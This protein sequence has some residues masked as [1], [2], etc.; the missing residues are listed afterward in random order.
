MKA[1]EI[2]SA[3]FVPSSGFET[4]LHTV[5]Q[6]SNPLVRINAISP[7]EAVAVC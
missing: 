5:V 2:H 6:F 4:L 1:A 7:I 3:A